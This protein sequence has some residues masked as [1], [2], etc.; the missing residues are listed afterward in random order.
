M[1]TEEEAGPGAGRGGS[2][3]AQSP[4]SVICY[5]DLTTLTATTP[6]KSASTHV[7]APNFY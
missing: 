3:E 5:N 4:P 6:L 2:R 7:L 1:F